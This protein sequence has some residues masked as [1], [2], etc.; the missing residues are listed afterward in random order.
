MLGRRIPSSERVAFLY[1]LRET[2]K[3][4]LSGSIGLLDYR[5]VSAFDS[6]EDRDTTAVEILRIGIESGSLHE[7]HGQHMIRWL[8]QKASQQEFRYLVAK[9]STDIRFPGVR[10][11]TEMGFLDELRFYR[12]YLHPP[13][14]LNPDT[15]YEFYRSLNSQPKR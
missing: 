9:G 6:A 14:P 12:P 3:N 15:G 7:G 10:E 4:A 13:I 1:T 2:D 8:A 5:V 11:M